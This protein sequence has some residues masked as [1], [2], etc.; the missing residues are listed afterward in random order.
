[1]LE[2]VGCLSEQSNQACQE[3]SLEGLNL[4]LRITYISKLLSRISPGDSSSFF[5]NAVDF[6]L[7]LYFTCM[8]ILPKCVSVHHVHATCG[9]QKR[10]SD[11]LELELGMPVGHHVSE[12]SPI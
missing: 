11:S 10:V 4:R 9:G 8:S 2:K 12:G 7:L 1:M 3:G 6:F 5:L